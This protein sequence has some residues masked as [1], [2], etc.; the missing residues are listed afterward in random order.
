MTGTNAASFAQSNNC[1][2]SLAAGG[3][4]TI[5]VRFTPPATGTFKASLT[6]VDNAQS[7][8][9]TQTVALSGRAN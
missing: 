5:A 6:I 1:G 7:G 4:C 3:N 9:G 2:N 8:G